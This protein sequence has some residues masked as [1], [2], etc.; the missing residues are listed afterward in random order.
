M[1]QPERFVRFATITPKGISVKKI[2]FLFFLSFSF[3]FASDDLFDHFLDQQMSVEAKLLDQNLSKE[4][5]EKIRKQQDH[6]YQIFFFDFATDP[7][8]YTD[9]NNTYSKEISKLRI[10]YNYNR[11]RGYKLAAMRDE[12]RLYEYHI[13][14]K[15]KNFLQN[16]LLQTE[17][18]SEKYF[19]DK[20]NDMI[21]ASFSTYTPLDKT[22]Y[23]D[24]LK[25]SKGGTAAEQLREE[26]ENLEELE[27]VINTFS[28]QLIENSSKIYNL[29]KATR[30]KLFALIDKISKYPIAKEIDKSLSRFNINTAQILLLI[31]IVLFITFINL[32]LKFTIDHILRYRKVEEKE[33]DY[34]HTHITKL[35][36][37]ITTALI[38]Q[39]ILIVYFGIDSKSFII[40]KFFAVIYVLLIA[41]LLYRITNTVAYLK[42]EKLQKSK[43]LRKE[44]F[45]LLI[46]AIN[47]SIIVVAIIAILI[48]FGINLTALLS[49]L[50]I[51]GFAIAFAAKDSISN[52]FGSI[53]ILLG[54]LFE[55]GDWIEAGGVDGT[56]VEIGLRATTLRTFDNAL[57]SIPNFKLVNE[58]IKNWSRRM[59]GR[60]IKMHIGVTYESNFDD[61]KQ[62]IKDIR[63]ML[64]EH[65]GISGSGTKYVSN[66]RSSKLVSA[67]DFK[68]IK[69]TSLVYMDEFADSSVNILLYCFSK[70]VVWAEWLE[71]KEDVMFKIEEI[72]K[73][74]HLQFAYPAM[75]IHQATDEADK[76]SSKKSGEPE[77]P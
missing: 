16:V 4:E 75:V 55:Q 35:I 36:Y 32:I 66:Y 31:F 67:D 49:G 69:R 38:V 9:R 21:A 28:A 37:I 26:L 47:I 12:L 10:H 51:G 14:S 43:I 77:N 44:V 50:G 2:F 11:N 54:D 33:I 30:S 62:A 1:V 60:R 48:I 42:M 65:P 24:A 5:R 7:K 15:I 52:I 45:N 57:I 19:E 40:S 73:K 27:D 29:G 72:L 64:K 20:L 23:L 53:S 34:I 76:E 18:R 59:I 63:A 8:N 6:D 22:K 46:K 70:S 17:N 39:L 58:E 25:K 74:N 13:K 41:L 56:V 61:I 68:G 71:V 3:L